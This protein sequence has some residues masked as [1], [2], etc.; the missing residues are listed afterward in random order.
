VFRPLRRREAGYAVV[1]LL[2]AITYIV[3]IGAS[4]GRVKSVVLVFQIFTVL[5]VLQVSDA[6]R[7]VRY[8]AYA[9]LAVAMVIAILSFALPGNADSILVRATALLSVA[10][11]FVAPWSIL[12]HLL[13]RPT[14]DRE[15]L[16]GAIAAYLLLG[17]FFAFLY[18]FAG[19]VRGGGFF[20]PS[21]PDTLANDLFFS[22]TTATTTGYG[23]LIPAGNPGQT[24]AVL[25][26][27]TGQLFLVIAVARVVTSF[28][29]NALKGRGSEESNDSKGGASLESAQ[30]RPI[31]STTETTSSD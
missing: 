11:Y 9:T 3:C 16:L 7:T 28:I 24:F 22:F 17:M 29:P 15:S 27:V 2:I 25:E 30:G 10:L 31:S 12:R 19:L 4:S 18:A 21:T 6:R 8:V 5:V 20:G 1:L 14:V 13:E 23:N 26:M